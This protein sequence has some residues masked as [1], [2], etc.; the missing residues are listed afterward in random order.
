MV[1]EV[2]IDVLGAMLLFGEET[3]SQRDAAEKPL[4]QCMIG[5]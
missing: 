1:Q 2:E 5:Y 4:E 3:E